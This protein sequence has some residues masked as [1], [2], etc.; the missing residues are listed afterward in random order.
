MN[1]N[2]ITNTCSMFELGSVSTSAIEG[3]KDKKDFLKYAY[4][5]TNY[6]EN[7][8][9][10]EHCQTLMYNTTKTTVAFAN[11]L[12]QLGFKRV[13][14]YR[15]NEDP[16]KKVHVWMLDLTPEWKKEYKKVN[17]IK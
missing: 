15:S 2:G 12:K 3:L 11:K 8:L 16:K 6:G 13:H 5:N 10:G 7:H 4:K 1:I 14:R 9:W 17:K